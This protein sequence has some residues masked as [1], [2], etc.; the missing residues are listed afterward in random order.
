MSVDL[1]EPEGP[2]MATNSPRVDLRRRRRASA[3]TAFSPE[4]YVLVMSSSWMRALSTVR[5][6]AAALGGRQ[7]SNL[8]TALMVRSLCS[9]VSAGSS[10]CAGVRR[11]RIILPSCKAASC[12]P[13]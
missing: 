7:D 5:R 1:P 2:M 10:Q 12:E 8:K 3:C 4:S 6:G 9:L 13:I 11:P